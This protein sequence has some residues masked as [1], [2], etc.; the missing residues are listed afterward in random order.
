M[1]RLYRV[2]AF[3]YVMA[4]NKEEAVDSKPML[5]ECSKDAS[6]ASEAGVDYT[7]WWNAIPFNSDDDRTCG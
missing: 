2:D 1:K 5:S 3:W 7:D 6:L 4:E